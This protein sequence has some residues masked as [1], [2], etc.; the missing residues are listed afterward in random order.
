[1]A[2]TILNPD[3]E[4]HGEVATKS[5]NVFMGYH[6]EENKTKEVEKLRKQ[7]SYLKVSISNLT[8]G[9]PINKI[10]VRQRKL[11]DETNSVS[12]SDTRSSS[13][14]IRYRVKYMV[15]YERSFLSK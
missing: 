3:H 8:I 7:I 11:S 13:A 6:K 5:R 2:N 9:V 10:D 1:M 15:S 12:L 4:G 14:S